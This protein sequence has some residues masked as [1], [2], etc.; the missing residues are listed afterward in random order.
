MALRCPGPS[1]CLARLAVVGTLKDS[2]SPQTV[3]T[4]V[5]NNNCDAQRDRMGFQKNRKILK[6]PFH[7]AEQH[8]EVPQNAGPSERLHFLLVRFLYASKENEPIKRAKGT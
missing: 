6:K 7:E 2:V 1:G 4:S 5:S 8:R 3:L